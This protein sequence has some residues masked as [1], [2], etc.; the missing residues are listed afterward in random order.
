[1]GAGKTTFTRELMKVLGSKDEISSPTY[2]LVNEYQANSGKI[3][4]FDLF[5]IKDEAELENLGFQEYL[6]NGNLSIVEWPDYFMDE[7]LG[8]DLHK[9]SIEKTKNGRRAVFE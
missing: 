6:E 3:Y 9:L 8:W 7:F 5:R 4:H 2:A 1:M